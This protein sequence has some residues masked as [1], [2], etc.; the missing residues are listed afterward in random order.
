[1][2][3]I[4]FMGHSTFVNSITFSE[5]VQRGYLADVSMPASGED[6]FLL[7]TYDFFFSIALRYCKLL[8]LLHTSKNVRQNSQSA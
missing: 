1:M 2:L 6:A 3:F 7:H 8:L 5:I 4:V